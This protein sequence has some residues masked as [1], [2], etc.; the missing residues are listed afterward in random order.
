[1]I[2]EYECEKCDKIWEIEKAM[3]DTIPKNMKCP[4]CKCVCNR[5]W[6]NMTIKVPEHMKATSS[7]Y[8]SDNGSNMDYLKNRMNKG[9]RPSGKDKVLY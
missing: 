2:Y 7:L 6:N 9:T 1:M 8:N 3:T 4:E 5:V